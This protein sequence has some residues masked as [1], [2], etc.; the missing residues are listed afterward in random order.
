MGISRTNSKFRAEGGIAG[1]LAGAVILIAAVWIF[2]L[3]LSGNLARVHMRHKAQGV[4]MQTAQLLRE[5]GE[6]LSGPLKPATR[7]ELR[8]LMK[9]RE[10]ERMD[11]ADASGRV[12]WS[13]AN[14]ANA[15]RIA[16]T[17]ETL[18]MRTYKAGPAE[19]KRDFAHSAARIDAPAALVALDMDVTGMIAWYKRISF[20]VAK[21]I[22][23]V[24]LGGFF[25]TGMIMFGRYHDRQKAETRLAALRRENAREQEKVRALQKQLDELNAAMAQF[26]RKIGSA[27]KEKTPRG[28]KAGAKT[29]GAGKRKAG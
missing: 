10:V 9:Y 6:T 29:A 5:S 17:G 26:N 24:L 15:G 28:E 21:T 8:R 22:T 23:T 19:L 1:L 16:M 2:A 14:D 3:L 18:E 12:I 4:T 13:S 25:V 20:M 11:I 7:T 27:M